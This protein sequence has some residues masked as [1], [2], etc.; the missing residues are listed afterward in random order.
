MGGMR[1]KHPQ[2]APKQRR[3]QIIY[4]TEAEVGWGGMYRVKCG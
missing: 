3:T 4:A 2:V 1:E